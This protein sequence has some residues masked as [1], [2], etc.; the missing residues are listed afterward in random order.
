MESKPAPAKKKRLCVFNDSLK[1][2]FPYLRSAPNKQ[3]SS[4]LCSICNSV[5]SIGSGGKTSVVEHERTSKHK[6]CLSARASTSSV[7]SF[8]KKSIP[9][10]EEFNLAIQEGTFAY[11]TVFHNQSFRSMDCTSNLV[12]TF[13]N[14]KFTCARTKCESIVKNVFAPWAH[15][16]L[17]K[18]LSIANFVSLS[19]DT[20]NHG[21]TKLLPI[22]VRYF[23]PAEKEV[24]VKL[25]DFI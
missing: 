15:S 9:S 23:N 12:K 13:Y 20:S 25:L 7:V 14:K 2:M 6:S 24:K 8:F 19:I 10:D 22:I 21:D 5:F 4:V 3:Q 11:H 16:E 1:S 17:V 18:A